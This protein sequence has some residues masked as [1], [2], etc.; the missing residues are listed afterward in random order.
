MAGF[1]Q[2]PEGFGEGLDVDRLNKLAVSLQSLKDLDSIDMPE[3]EKDYVHSMFKYY[4]SLRGM[5]IDT[6]K[7]G[8][9]LSPENLEVLKQID[10]MNRSVK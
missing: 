4:N 10:L 7:Y 5:R 9:N 8:G 1:G 2:F 3:V 6:K